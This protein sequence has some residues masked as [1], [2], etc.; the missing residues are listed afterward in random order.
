MPVA[1]PLIA[2]AASI[3]AGVAVVGAATTTLSL[4]AGGLMIAGGALSAV[5]AITGNADLT[6]WG[7]IIGLAGG[8]GGLATGAFGAG[9]SVAADQSA[10]ETARLAAQN[11]TLAQS[12]APTVVAPAAADAA[13]LAADAA[14]A[15]VD[16]ATSAAPG[17]AAP[18]ADVPTTGLVGSNMA[19]PPAGAD[20]ATFASLDPAPADALSRA[21]APAP[22]GPSGPA[23][24]GG[25]TPGIDQSAAETARLTAQNTPNAPAEPGIFE[26]IAGYGKSAASFA[27]D[28]KELVNT[29][30]G[31]VQGAMKSYG[32]Q[33]L[34][35]QRYAMAE[36]AEARQRARLNASVM[37]LKMP[38]YQAPGSAR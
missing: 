11:G 25:V 22:A 7:G 36:E 24:P 4:I 2:A 8:V 12:A 5:G 38:V 35:K 17:L 14:P 29:A 28:N 19:A 32:D 6:K 1:I 13:A 10:A 16:A 33:D 15:A 9:A 20:P 30:S 37:G 18:V 23:G 21:G 3:S 27:K 31:L 26:R 34:L